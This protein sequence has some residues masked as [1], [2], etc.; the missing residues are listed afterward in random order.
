MIGPSY[1]SPPKKSAFS[2]LDALLTCD[3]RCRRGHDGIRERRCEPHRGGGLRPQTAVHVRARFTLPCP[4]KARG[5]GRR[6]PTAL[7]ERD[8]HARSSRSSTSCSSPRCCSCS[9]STMVRSIFNTSSMMWVDEVSPIF[10]VNLAFLG[11]AVSYGRGQFIAITLLVDRAPQVWNGVLEGVRRVARD[12]HL[13]PDRRLLG[14]AAHRQ[15][16]GEVAPARH[17]L[18]VDD[19]ADHA[20]LRAV[21]H[22]RGARPRGPRARPQSRSAGDW[23]RPCVVGLLRWSARCWVRIRRCS[24]RCWA[25][26]S[27]C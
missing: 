13:A 9:R 10:L 18:H 8:R 21:R 15:C 2:N 14:A 17:Q 27:S 1:R 24:T 7:A 11:G 3:P 20:R 4:P 6:R 22:P 23:S 26:P 16:R 19:D 25:W 12:R 5:G